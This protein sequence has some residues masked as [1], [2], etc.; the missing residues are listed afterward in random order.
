MN[1]KNKYCLLSEL[2]QVQIDKLVGL[3]P[4]AD[5]FDFSKSEVLIGFSPNG[6]AGTWRRGL[7]DEIITYKEML[8]LLGAK[9]EE[10]KLVPH[11]HQKE[12]IAWANGEEIEVTVP[13][14]SSEL[15]WC[16]ASAPSWQDHLIYRV[17]PKLTPTQLRIQKLTEELMELEEQHNVECGIG[18]VMGEVGCQQFE[19]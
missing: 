11:V 1:I 12:I 5:Y 7:T 15:F 14:A 9:E 17:K 2:A 13:N 18:L 3:V 8:S 6:N 10:E 4:C 16:T 19:D